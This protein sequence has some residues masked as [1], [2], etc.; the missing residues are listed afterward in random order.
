MRLFA[1]F[2][3]AMGLAVFAADASAQQRQ[4][5]QG[6][7]FAGGGRGG[8][9][10][11]LRNEAVQKELK[12]DKEQTD[13]AAEAIKKVQDKHADDFAKLREIPREERREKTTELTKVISTETM[14][15]ISE[16]L[17]PEQIKRLKQI[18]LQQAGVDAFT[19][20]DVEKALSIDTEQKT[21]LKTIAE[22]STTKMRELRGFG[23]PG[24]Q[25]PPRGQGGAGRGGADQTKILALRKETTEKVMAVLTDSQ[26]KT[27]TEMTGDAFEV[28]PTRRTAPKKDD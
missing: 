23:A 12:M 15:A 4:P 10:S 27:W 22:E 8:V 3:L 5:G 2:A 14:T 25:R 1:G 9:S 19:R 11:L 6:R 28:P 13:K 21:K 26:K 18:E 24:G 17:K 16:V 7:G 20:A